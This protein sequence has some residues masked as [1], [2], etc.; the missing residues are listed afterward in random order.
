MIC[1]FFKKITRKR[2]AIVL[3]KIENGP[4]SGL[5]KTYLQEYIKEGS[6]KNI[7]QAKFI[8]L[9]LE[10]WGDVKL[11]ISNWG[12]LVTVIKQKVVP[13]DNSGYTKHYFLP[14]CWNASE[15]SI[16]HIVNTMNFFRKHKNYKELESDVEAKYWDLLGE[17][18]I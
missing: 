14:L 11:A 6:L 5:E 8:Y 2:K 9:K 3:D 17:G 16:A 10:G 15:F 13:G 4:F 7:N 12:S 18:G 1:R